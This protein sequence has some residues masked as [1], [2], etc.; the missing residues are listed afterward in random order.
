MDAARAD[1]ERPLRA[2]AA[3]NLTAILH[4]AR[5]AFAHEGLDVGVEEIARRAGVGKGTLYRRFPT[6]DALVWAIVEEAITEIE[7]FADEALAMDDPW[8]GLEHFLVSAVRLQAEDHGFFDAVAERAE[9]PQELRRRVLAAAGAVLRP[10]QDAGAV[11]ADLG[12]S[13]VAMVVR[14]VGATTHAA[15]LAGGGEVWPRYLRLAL[16]ALRPGGA[17]APLPGEAPD[18]FAA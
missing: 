13:D 5:S 2:D 9:P 12:A 14:M 6:K 1:A 11:R 18:P 15:A 4:A 7:T 17:E 8:D 16:D 10:A 3:R